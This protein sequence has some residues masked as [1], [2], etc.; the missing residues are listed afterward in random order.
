MEDRKDTKWYIGTIPAIFDLPSDLP[1]G[2][3]RL[4]MDYGFKSEKSWYTYYGFG[5]DQN[6]YNFNGEGIGSVYPWERN[7]SNLYS[8]PIAASGTDNTGKKISGSEI[9]RRC[10]W[11]LLWGRNSN[12]YQGVV[13]DEDKKSVAISPRNSSMMRLYCPDSLLRDMLSN[14]TWNHIS[15]SMISIPAAICRGATTAASGR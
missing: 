8:P 14:T 13:A 4:R 1:P 11:V 9:R 6:W 3:Y 2:I 12:G 15:C 5:S 7:L 10:Y